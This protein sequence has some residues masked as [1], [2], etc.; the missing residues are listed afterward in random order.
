MKSGCHRID[1][2]QLVDLRRDLSKMAP[3]FKNIGSKKILYMIVERHAILRLFTLTVE[4][5]LE[6]EGTSSM[7]HE[8]NGPSNQQE[9]K[10]KAMVVDSTPA[11][12]A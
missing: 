4:R 3:Y 11:T 10:D 12:S 9:H 7:G 1:T 8:D 5:P 6:V 2:S